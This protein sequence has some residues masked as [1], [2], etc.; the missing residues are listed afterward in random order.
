MSARRGRGSAAGRGRGAGGRGAPPPGW[1]PSGSPVAQ[2]EEPNSGARDEQQARP[3]AVLEPPTESWIFEDGRN[4][5]AYDKKR[6]VPKFDYTGA[7]LFTPP[8]RR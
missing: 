5:M 2:T 1:S 3:S 7:S 6:A 8:P 4:F